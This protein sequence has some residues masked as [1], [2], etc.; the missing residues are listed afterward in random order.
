MTKSAYGGCHHPIIYTS[1]DVVARVNVITSEKGVN[2]VY[3][4]VGKDTYK[5]LTI[6]ASVIIILSYNNSYNNTLAST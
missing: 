5:V 2:V 4:S 1:G 3:D 6:C